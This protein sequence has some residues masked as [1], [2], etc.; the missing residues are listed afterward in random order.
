[1]LVRKKNPSWQPSENKGLQVGEALEVTDYRRLVEAGM[2]DL[3]DED[4]N[5][6]PLPGTIFVCGICFTKCDSHGDYMYHALT[7]HK[8]MIKKKQVDESDIPVNIPQKEVQEDFSVTKAL[9]ETAKETFGDRMK[10][11]RAA[12]RAKSSEQV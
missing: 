7:A 12:K 6:L 11:A 9:K 3:V 8:D 2:A 10:K 5:I 1:M 4:G